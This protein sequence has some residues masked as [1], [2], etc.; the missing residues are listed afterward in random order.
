MNDDAVSGSWYGS[1]DIYTVRSLITY[2]VSTTDNSITASPQLLFQS[3]RLAALQINA[4]TQYLVSSYQSTPAL[5]LPYSHPQKEAQ[6]PVHCR[7]P[8]CT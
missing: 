8:D 3:S 6:S 7:W 1:K 5:N 2:N 4:Q